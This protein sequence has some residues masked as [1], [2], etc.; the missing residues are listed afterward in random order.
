MINKESHILLTGAT[1][2]LGGY[3]LRL[4][5]KKGYN[6]ISCT[7]RKTSNFTLI[8]EVKDRVDWK[9]C[10]LLDE[11]ELADA[12]SGVDVVIHVAAK[13]SLSNKNRSSV[14]SM[15]TEVTSHMINA[16]LRHKI[17]KFIFVSSVAAFGVPKSGEL[18]HEETEWVDRPGHSV[19]SI[20]KQLAERE[21]IRGVAEGLQAVIISPAMV[22][23]AGV[24]NSMSVSM[25]RSI[26]KGFPYYPKGSVGVVDVRDVAE[27]ILLVMVKTDI[28]GEKYIA[29][30]EN[31][32]HKAIIETVCKAFDKVPPKKVLSPFLAKVSSSLFSIFEFVVG[33]NKLI[34]ADSIQLA[35]HKYLFDNSKSREQ[36]GFNYRDVKS[37]FEEIASVFKESYPKAKKFGTLDI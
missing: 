14:M 15:N 24:W 7:H 5:L 9:L 18:I 2:F 16:S 3:V 37:S 29:S 26:Y 19:Y 27:L 20:S 11:T 6:N 17:E 13:V 10:D 32:E 4:L 36:L 30:A 25:I 8:Q 31:W 34:N 21:V 23:G 12:F 28:A 35:Q 1:G 22:I 33:E